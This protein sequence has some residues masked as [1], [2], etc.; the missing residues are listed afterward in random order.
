MLWLASPFA[1][2]ASSCS[3]RAVVWACSVLISLPSASE[4]QLQGRSGG[5]CLLVPLHSFPQLLA[6]ALE[7]PSCDLVVYTHHVG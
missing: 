1:A 6:T 2:A 3:C 7:L 4:L 5:C